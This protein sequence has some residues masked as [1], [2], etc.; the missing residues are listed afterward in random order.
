M[1]LEKSWCP[2]A[3][4]DKEWIESTTDIFTR[5]RELN[6]TNKPV[7]F[8][9]GRDFSEIDEFAEF[10][11][12]YVMENFMGEYLKT[13]FDEGLQAAEKGLMVI[14]AADTDDTGEKDLNR[15]RLGLVLSMLHDNTYFA[16]DFGPR[17]HGQAWW[18]EEYDA[19][20]G[21]PLGDYYR[22]EDAYYREFE[23][24]IVVAS[25]Y[26]DTTVSFDQEH[27][28]ITTGSKSSV[29]QIDKGDG[30]IYIR[31]NHLP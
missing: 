1:V 17:D 7:I 18:F 13:T 5:I 2:E 4:S 23:N 15:M 12:G 27:V 24:G 11:D 30:R 29:F 21:K 16:Y 28:D 20:P 6:V 9:S 14:Y 10:M 19:E 3:I 25:P 31:D 22:E 8:N 26:T